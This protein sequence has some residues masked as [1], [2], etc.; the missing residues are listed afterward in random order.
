MPKAKIAI[1]GG[2]IVGLAH[3]Y[4]AARRGWS[5]V[6]FERNESARGA[7][8]RNFGM[9]WPIGQPP[10]E[11]LRLALRSRSLWLDMIE[12]TGMEIAGTGS[13]HLAY[14]SDEAAVL[15]EFVEVSRGHGYCCHWFNAGQVRSR[16]PAAQPEGLLGGMWSE[17]ELV[18]DPR[19]VAASLPGY[20]SELYGVQVRANATVYA[21]ELPYVRTARETW[22]VEQVV[23]C[24]GDD[25]SS[26]YPDA[27]AS[28]GLVKCKLQMMRTGPQPKEWKLG[29]GLAGGLTLRFYPS[30]RICSTLGA[31]EQRIANEMPLYDQY[32]IHV[33]AS[34][35]PGGEVTIGDSHEYGGTVEV[36]DKPEIDRLILSY[37]EKFLT[38]PRPEIVERWHGVY[39]KHAELPYFSVSPEPGVRIVTG[40][41][42]AGM[43]MSFGVAEKTWSEWR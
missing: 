19:E 31:L 33:M 24:S 29:A 30:F 40:L 26:L 37:L 27:F 34:Q 3:A 39:A 12:E 28:S 13:F 20:L 42:G 21:I 15:Q 10:G 8:I 4:L 38:L 11:R 18:V 7:S 36:F 9:I 6:V 25:F 22:E 5:V 14:H 2:G 17:S 1:V 32:G 16:C 41:G 43:T 23:V 35:T